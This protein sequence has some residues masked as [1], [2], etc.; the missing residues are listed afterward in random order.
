MSSQSWKHTTLGGRQWLN[1]NNGATMGGMAWYQTWRAQRHELWPGCL[2]ILKNPD[3]ESSSTTEVEAREWHYLPQRKSR[4]QGC[5]TL[6]L[7]VA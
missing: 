5:R 7:G 2:T 4:E 3:L 6:D 1:N